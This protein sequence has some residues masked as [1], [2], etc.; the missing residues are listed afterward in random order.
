MPFT[1]DYFPTKLATDLS[2]V[3]DP[4][5][6]RLLA[7]PEGITANPTIDLL[8]GSGLVVANG[9]PRTG[10]VVIAPGYHH[11]DVLTAAAEQNDRR[12][13]P[14]STALAGFAVGVR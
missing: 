9:L 2:Q 4:Q 6:A 11:I 5:I 8:G 12:P 10:R 14:I 13:E 1:E 7:H 3:S